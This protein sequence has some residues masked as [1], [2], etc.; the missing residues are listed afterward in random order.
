MNQFVSPSYNP[1]TSF[2]IDQP[3]YN[4]DSSSNFGR[5]LIIV[6]IFLLLGAII[7]GSM[8]FHLYSKLNQEI[9]DFKTWD[10]SNTKSK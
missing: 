8:H 6:L 7:I 1:N 4:I 10:D 5:N 9:A 2:P 3:V